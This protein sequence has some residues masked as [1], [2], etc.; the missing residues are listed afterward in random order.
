M[1]SKRRLLALLVL[2]VS[3]NTNLFSMEKQNKRTRD[4]IDYI[5]DNN[6]YFNETVRDNKR[7]RLDTQDYFNN[8]PKEI[9]QMIF[10]LSIIDNLKAIN[11]SDNYPEDGTVYGEFKNTYELFFLNKNIGTS[12]I[13]LFKK[14]RKSF[15]NNQVN[16]DLNNNL[17][18]IN[19]LIKFCN[20][21][22][23]F[24]LMILY[25][26][27][28]NIDNQDI[29]LYALSF[30]NPKQTK[31]IPDLD[32]NLIYKRTALC[33]S[34]L[35]GHNDIAK[36]FLNSPAHVNA[37]KI[38]HGDIT[39][40]ALRA[41]NFE[42]GTLTMQKAN[43]EFK[44][45]PQASLPYSFLLEQVDANM[46]I[47]YLTTYALKIIK[48]LLFSI[49]QADNQI[50]IL[51]CFIRCLKEII[52]TEISRK[53]NNKESLPKQDNIEQNIIDIT[54]EQG[55]TKQYIVNEQNIINEIKEELRKFLGYVLL[56]QDFLKGPNA[57]E[58]VTLFLK[59]GARTDLKNY[60]GYRIIDIAEKEYARLENKIKISER[61]ALNLD[62]FK[63]SEDAVLTRLNAHNNLCD[64]K[65]KIEKIILL[66]KN[67][68]LG[69]KL[70][71]Q[72]NLDC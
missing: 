57:L 13:E 28:L 30:N 63:K 22:I 71:R 61:T 37:F 54:F 27:G 9:I 5:D 6:S 17:G 49:K 46:D 36:F 11:I 32:S 1:I 65:T 67:S 66:L 48:N 52:K 4:S 72:Q 64:S 24:K 70:L 35:S 14:L 33:Q 43:D 25:Y 51:E 55:F 62:G 12:A 45:S 47:K 39:T 56:T 58:I 15:N 38:L 23:E 42:I 44:N 21:E 69:S 18:L 40:H 50:K 68:D 34:I 20:S 53:L 60:K 26:L 2:F 7:L 3:I 59:Y 19:Y 29:E 31:S 8:L 16:Q 10:G 41:Q